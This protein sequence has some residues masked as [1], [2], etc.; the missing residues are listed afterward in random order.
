MKNYSFS[1]ES[2]SFVAT[3]PLSSGQPYLIGSSF[4][5][6]SNSLIPGQSGELFLT[7]VWRLPKGPKDFLLGQKVYWDTSSKVITGGADIDAAALP[8]TLK[9]VGTSAEI[10]DASHSEFLCRLNGVSV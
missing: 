7:G 10:S 3:E 5:V 4:G 8:S 9:L 6:V 1:G 2:I